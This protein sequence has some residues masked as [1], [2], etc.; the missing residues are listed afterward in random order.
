MMRHLL[1]IFFSLVLATAAQAFELSAEHAIPYREFALHLDGDTRDW[2]TPVLEAAFAERDGEAT[3]RNRVRWRAVW[4]T[5]ALW[6]A[7]DVDD[8]E[9]VSAPSQLVVEQFH[10]F[11]SLQVYLDPRGDSVATMNR[12]DVNL[13]LLPDG[14]SGALRGDDVVREL[15]HAMVPQRE[16]TPLLH[17]YAAR[18]TAQGWRAELRLPFAAL[19]I[20]PKTGHTLRIDVANNDWRREHGPGQPSTI[21]LGEESDASPESMPDAADF[22]PL[23]WSGTRD[24]GFPSQWPRVVLEGAPPLLERW[25]SRFGATTMLATAIALAL[26]LAAMS[27]LALWQW[28]RHRMR[29][30]LQRLA[31]MHALPLPNQN[32]TEDTPPTASMAEARLNPPVATEDNESGVSLPDDA[33]RA[34]SL[35]DQ[36]FARRVLAFAR[37]QVGTV[38]DPTALAAQFHVSLRTLQRRLARGLGTTPQELLLATRLEAAHQLLCEGHLRVAQVADRVGFEDVSHFARRFKAAYGVAPSVL[39]RRGEPA[40]RADDPSFPNH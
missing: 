4:D 9:I 13:V 6:L 2:R 26:F 5:D 1:L 11:D 39:G 36:H 30:L 37:E 38:R 33:S 20:T 24:Y 25:V 22:A 15:R 40:T 8:A 29:L 23:A 27:S 18:L 7:I 17:A 32:A 3:A 31:S 10:Q 28:H 16:S 21:P 35:R 34:E 19:G 12:D 14:R